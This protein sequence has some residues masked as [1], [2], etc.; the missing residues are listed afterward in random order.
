MEERYSRRELVE[1]LIG[2]LLVATIGCCNGSYGNRQRE[3]TVPTSAPAQYGKEQ[4]VSYKTRDFSEDKDE[5][6][7]ARMIFGE[8]SNCS[9]EEKIA[10][11]YSAINR[12]NDGNSWNGTSLREVILKPAQY[13]CFNRADPNRKRV[14]NPQAYDEKSF[15][16]C[17][18]IAG[19]VLAGRYNDPTN[20][21]THYFN[22]NLAQPSWQ[23]NLSRIGKIKTSKGLSA[24]KFY[25]EENKAQKTRKDFSKVKKKPQTKRKKH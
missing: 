14:M 12:V 25:K 4:T 1:G 13:S 11:A 22:P 6:L 9:D 17:L 7:L 2:S 21:A 18:D 8:A 23:H 5:V 3:R 19:K 10:V 20:G 16:H 24:H 15:E